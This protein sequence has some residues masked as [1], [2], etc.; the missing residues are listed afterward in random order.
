MYRPHQSRP[1]ARLLDLFLVA[2]FQGDFKERFYRAD[3]LAL[4]KAM[5]KAGGGEIEAEPARH[6]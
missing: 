2:Y 3:C 5:A 6:Q 1:R 4:I